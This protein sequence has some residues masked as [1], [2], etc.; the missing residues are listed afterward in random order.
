MLFAH[1]QGLANAWCRKLRGEEEEKE[2]EREEE[3]QEDEEERR[4]KGGLRGGEAF[5]N[6]VGEGETTSKA[7]ANTTSKTKPKTIHKTCR[8]ASGFRICL[9]QLRVTL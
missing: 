9:A 8:Q 5:E 2:D 4:E 7:K 3:E 6:S 1:I